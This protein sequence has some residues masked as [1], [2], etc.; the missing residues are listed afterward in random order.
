MRLNR[1]LYPRTHLRQPEPASDITSGQVM[2][3]LIDRAG[4]VGSMTASS[5]GQADDPMSRD[6]RKFC[7]K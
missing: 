1:N 7:K 2:R 4:R 3:H 6:G 5:S